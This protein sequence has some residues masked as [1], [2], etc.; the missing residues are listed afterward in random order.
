MSDDTVSG[1]TGRGRIE[2]ERVGH[3]TSDGY[4]AS[5]PS[6]AVNPDNTRLF[7][8][9]TSQLRHSRL[10]LCSWAVGSLPREAVG[11]RT[12]SCISLCMYVEGT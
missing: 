1:Q 3:G 11:R 4:S 10:G 9:V 7:D 6:I 2:D 8:R 5:T 12:P